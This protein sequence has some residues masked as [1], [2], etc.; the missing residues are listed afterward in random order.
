MRLQNPRF[1]ADQTLRKTAMPSI[2]GRIAWTFTAVAM[3]FALTHMLSPSLLNPSREP[4]AWAQQGND[5][6]DNY[7]YNYNYNNSSNKSGNY[8]SQYSN[9]NYSNNGYNYNNSGG[10]NYADGANN[11]GSTGAGAGAPQGGNYSQSNAQ[12]YGSSFNAEG[13]ILNSNNPQSLEFNSSGAVEDPYGQSYNAQSVIIEESNVLSFD[14]ADAYSTPAAG[15]TSPTEEVT[16]DPGPEEIPLPTLK[17]ER[18]SLPNEFSGAPPIHGTAGVL[19]VGEAP[20]QYMIREGDTLYDICDQLLDE[21]EY[22]PKLWALNPEIRNPHFIWPGMVLRFYPGDDTLPPFLEIEEGEKLDPVVLD[23]EY[24]VEDLVRAPLPAEPPPVS[25]QPQLAAL[26]DYD[27]IKNFPEDQITFLQRDGVD[28]LEAV[29]SIFMYT[30]RVEELAEVKGTFNGEGSIP[31][32]GVLDDHEGRIS[33][34]QSYSV[35]R[36][37][38]RVRNPESRRRVGYQYQNVA[39]IQVTKV[40]DKDKAL[41]RSEDSW[42]FILPGDLLVEKIASTRRIDLNASRRSPSP[43]VEGTVVSFEL[44]SGQLASAGNF[45][46]IDNSSL[47]VGTTVPLYRK[48]GRDLELEGVFAGIED[49]YRYGTAQVVD[50]S[51]AGAIAYV[52]SSSL[53]VEIGDRTSPL[54]S[55]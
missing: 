44:P 3:V 54:S 52:I 12:N 4:S 40:L 15:T 8:N 50:A 6:N 26:V 14:Q 5:G 10:N 31:Q 17:L 48:R 23:G 29:Q 55:S 11:Q 21:P 41:F 36:Y 53:A 34:G 13:N 18:V 25:Y 32:E 27:Q 9:N 24:L 47:S 16:G 7:N 35:I 30:E 49:S 37:M 22:W 43:D 28:F 46:V 1:E 51:G 45:I 19:E 38:H 42:F 2:R 33:D 20:P 39:T